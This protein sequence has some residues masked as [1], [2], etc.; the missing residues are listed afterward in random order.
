MHI[1]LE[2][3]L[4][5]SYDMHK[6]IMMLKNPRKEMREDQRRIS[7]DSELKAELRRIMENPKK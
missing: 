4:D 5:V 1:Q 2:F 7:I 6:M 3:M